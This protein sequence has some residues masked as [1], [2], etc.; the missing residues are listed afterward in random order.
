M[1]DLST[2]VKKADDLKAQVSLVSC[3][4]Y[5]PSMLLERISAALEPLGGMGA[6]VKGGQ[7]VLL[8]PNML[9][10]KGPERAITTHPAFVEAVAR[11]VRQAGGVPVI[12]DSPGGAIRGIARVWKNTGMAD[13]AERAGI[14][15]VNFEASG[16]REI[17]SGRHRLFIAK[18]VLDADLVI[19]LAKLKT[20]SLTLLT[21]GVKNMFG[22]IPG[23]RKAEFHKLYP[24]PGEF[25][26]MLVELY[27]RVSPSLTIV[28]A[29]LSMEGNGPSSGRPVNTGLVAAGTDAVAVDAVLAAKIGF[30]PGDIATTRIAD[31]RGIGRG[32]LEDIIVVGDGK[33]KVIEG[34]L[35]PSNRG[36]SLIPRPLARMIAPLVWLRLEIAEERCTRCEMCKRSC[37]VATIAYVGDVLKIGQSGCIQCMCCHELCP[38]NAIDIKMSLLARLF[39]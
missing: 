4:G 27:S 6:F 36:I 9:S 28:D 11:L 2:S 35:L 5:D 18:P 16:L 17:E 3:D 29:I 13:M 12:G 37:P 10:A 8:K 26:E 25:S 38:E 24:K 14:E 33:D 7:R 15:M 34:F 20:H 32:R 30:A 39:I 21:C 23:F 19:N 1:A 22:V 31:E